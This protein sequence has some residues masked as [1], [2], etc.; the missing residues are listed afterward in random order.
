[1]REGDRHYVLSSWIRSY[2]AKGRDVRDHY[3]GNGSPFCDD[4]APIVRGL[5]ARSTVLVGHLPEHED[6]I[7]GWMAWEGDVLHYMLTKPNFRRMGVA[8]SM[9]QDFASM[10]VQ[11]THRTS[12]ALRCPIPA[13]W[14]YRRFRI[15]PQ[16]K[17]A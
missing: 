13:G 8:R 2:A 17:A 10:P 7:M 4:Y 5:V 11:F 3:E 16:E 14:A 15:W 6:I 12:D 1:M 9:L